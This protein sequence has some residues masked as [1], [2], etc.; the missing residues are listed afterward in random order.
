MAEVMTWQQAL[1]RVDEIKKAVAENKGMATAVMHPFFLFPL[2]IHM[3]E[4]SQ[5]YLDKFKRVLANHKVVFV[6]R[7]KE[8]EKGSQRIEKTNKRLS[9]LANSVK[10]NTKII[11]IDTL[12]ENPSPWSP[13]LHIPNQQKIK[14]QKELSQLESKLSRGFFSV[15]SPEPITSPQLE[16]DKEISRITARAEELDSHTWK[17]DRNEKML[18]DF[19]KKCGVKTL[20]VGG[21]QTKVAAFDPEHWPQGAI[22]IVIKPNLRENKAFIHHTRCVATFMQSVMKNAPKMKIRIMRKLLL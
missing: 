18:V 7:E 4:K 22:D 11:L 8:Q 1:G 17:F 2:D 13:D 16:F 6:L 15:L 19:I 9:S 21:Q 3:T 5:E 14:V 20:K 12:E 10:T